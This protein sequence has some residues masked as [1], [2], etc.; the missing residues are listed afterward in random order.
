MFYQVRHELAIIRAVNGFVQ[1]MLLAEFIW[2]TDSLE[3][4]RDNFGSEYGVCEM[5]AHLWS[6]HN[7][8]HVVCRKMTVTCFSDVSEHE[9]SCG[10]WFSDTASL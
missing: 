5:G 1:K 8:P 9:A 6:F 4:S 7:Q 2:E 10:S 3:I